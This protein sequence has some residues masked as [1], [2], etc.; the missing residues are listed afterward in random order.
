MGFLD[1]IK[2]FFSAKKE[3]VKAEPA[4]PTAPAGRPRKAC[5]KCGK[6]FSYDPSWDFIPNYCKDCKKQ[7]G[8]E[9]EEKQRAGAPRK[10]RRKCKECGNFFSFPNTIAHYPSYCPN[11][12]KRHQAAMKQ[13]YTR[14]Q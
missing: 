12:R 11:C 3:P 1:R 6:L 10:I 4:A 13:K 14:K 5:K 8:Q 7:F 2:S 9:K